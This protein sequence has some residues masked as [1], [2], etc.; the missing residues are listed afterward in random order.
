MYWITPDVA[1]EKIMTIAVYATLSFHFA[2]KGST[3]YVNQ[4]VIPLKDLF[5]YN[6]KQ[7]GRTFPVLL[8]SEFQENSL[9]LVY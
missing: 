5:W 6:F 3:R 1:L 4:Y 8:L 9:F 2:L 7:N